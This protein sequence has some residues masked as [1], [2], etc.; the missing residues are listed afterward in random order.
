MRARAAHESHR[1]RSREAFR[2][3]RRRATR[4]SCVGR[5]GA[6]DRALLTRG[7][8][9]RSQRACRRGPE[10]R[11]AV[12]ARRAAARVERVAAR[13]P[14]DRRCDRGGAAAR[15]AAARERVAAL[16]R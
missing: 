12:P 5:A 4:R 8:G 6:R 10:P 14:Q 3:H 16:R 2:H 11:H 7:A 9:P 1:D 15:L 13:A